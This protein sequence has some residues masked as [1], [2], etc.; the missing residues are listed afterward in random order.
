MGQD[1]T[2]MVH[3]GTGIPSEAYREAVML[4]DSLPQRA[5]IRDEDVEPWLAQVYRM[6]PDRLFW[7]INRLFGIGGSEIGT[8]VAATEGTFSFNSPEAIWDQKLLRAAPRPPMPDAQR[9]I[10][11]E[12][13]IGRAFLRATNGTRDDAALQALSELPPDPDH[14]W[15]GPNLNPDDIVKISANDMTV[16][17][18]VD[19][20]APRGSAAFSYAKKGCPLEYSCQ[21][22]LYNYRCNALKALGMEVDSMALVPFSC[23]EWRPYTIPVPF[24]ADL[25][26]KLLHVGDE[27]WNHN[28]LCGIRPQKKQPSLAF[29]RVELS[30]YDQRLAAQ[31]GALRAMQSAA[32]A[33]AERVEEEFGSRMLSSLPFREPCKYSAGYPQVEVVVKSEYAT[34]AMKQLASTWKVPEAEYTEAAAPSVNPEKLYQSLSTRG[35][36]M[37]GLKVN[38]IEHALRV[39]R[40]NGANA[41][42]EYLREELLPKLESFSIKFAEK[43]GETLAQMFVPTGAAPTMREQGAGS[44]KKSQPKSKP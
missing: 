30:E 44:K 31:Y 2:R 12:A 9:G 25:T 3:Q 17:Q 7:H 39:P 34:E 23:D 26:A 20:K 42:A 41:Q 1:K 35:V 11:L 28:V 38:R 8:L 19:Y 40:V 18:L 43:T 29:K 33:V 24:D 16:R 36:P 14:P 32:T 10:Y 27:F 37:D 4:I 22:H 13:E 21:L 15:I 6:E 5:H